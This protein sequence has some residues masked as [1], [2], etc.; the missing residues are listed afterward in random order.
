MEDIVF[1]KLRQ[2]GL[3]LQKKALDA[4]KAGDFDTAMQMLSEFSA[5]L[6][7]VELS[8]ERM[9]YLKRPVDRNIDQYKTLKAKADFEKH[10]TE[11][12]TGSLPN[13]TESE[14]RKVL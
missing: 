6:N 14:R 9:A 8:S 11:V 10:R 5:R 3:D 2:E 7:E 12:A 4:S 1:Q 13:A